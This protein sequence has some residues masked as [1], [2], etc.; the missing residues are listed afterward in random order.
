M[1]DYSLESAVPRLRRL[2][3]PT[4]IERNADALLYNAILVLERVKRGEDVS[5]LLA[6]TAFGVLKRRGG[7]RG[8]KRHIKNPDALGLE[9][10]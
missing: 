2:A 5:P 8:S 4:D 1:T 7:A 9:K 10:E 6:Q 3:P